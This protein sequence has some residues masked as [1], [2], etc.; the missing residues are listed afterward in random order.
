MGAYM[1]ST[2]KIVFRHP[3]TLKWMEIQ[4][5][6][7]EYGC[8]P[9]IHVHV[10]VYMYVHVPV[11]Y[12]HYVHMYCTHNSP[13]VCRHRRA[14]V[15]LCCTVILRQVPAAS[16]MVI[17]TDATEDINLDSSPLG[18]P[19][20][21]QDAAR[22][23]PSSSSAT[24]GTSQSQ[25]DLGLNLRR[26]DGLFVCRYCNKGFDRSFSVIRHERMHT[27]FKPCVCR[28]CGR[29]FSEPRNLRQH[30]ERFHSHT[31]ASSSS[32][33]SSREKASARHR[34][35]SSR[36]RHRDDDV[37]PSA[38]SG[39]ESL[40]FTQ[41]RPDSYS[42]HTSDIKPDPDDAR[43]PDPGGGERQTESPADSQGNQSSAGGA[44]SSE[45]SE[46]KL[47]SSIEMANEIREK[48][49][50]A[51]DVMVVIPSDAPLD[52][53]VPALDT[54]RSTISETTSW[55]N[56]S[57]SDYE[58]LSSSA[59]AGG[60]EIMSAPVRSIIGTYGRPMR[61]TQCK[62]LVCSCNRHKITC[63]CTSMCR[64][65]LFMRFA[66]VIDILDIPLHSC[67]CTRRATC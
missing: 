7:T 59:G 57:E 56:I 22:S 19:S 1:Y 13:D 39:A 41:T 23:S 55:S 5:T 63:T 29:G 25:P 48:E 52:S 3:H 2:R 17:L 28:H 24:P 21:L 37:S 62:R 6:L 44:N 67:T 14:V 20:A 47:D 54:P 65:D 58:P 9:P 27:G 40:P 12:I 33:S 38:H 10:Q 43:S 35:S 66:A 34:R 60:G 32:R 42:P 4:C 45:M 8:F 11:M 15:S 31:A 53:R 36:S 51:D 46:S 61:V 16:E 50:L 64:N 49:R 30:M 26:E 18:L